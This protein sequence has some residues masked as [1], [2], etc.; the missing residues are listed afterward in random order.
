MTK[1]EFKMAGYNVNDLVLKRPRRLPVK[2]KGVYTHNCNKLNKTNMLP[3]KN[4]KRV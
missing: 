2:E 4:I 3:A 1:R